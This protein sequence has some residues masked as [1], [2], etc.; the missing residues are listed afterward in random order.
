MRAHCIYPSSCQKA[1]HSHKEFLIEAHG[2]HHDEG[3]Q[4]RA[5]SYFA[6]NLKIKL[7]HIQQGSI[8]PSISQNT[9][10]K[11]Q[12]ELHI[13]RKKEKTLSSVLPLFRVPIILS[14]SPNTKPTI[15]K[16]V[17]KNFKRSIEKQYKLSVHETQVQA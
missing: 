3:Y 2:T 11:C 8:Y 4:V 5:P 16:F 9:H 15:V 17:P 10:I 14:Q 1:I 13:E 7:N 6:T 12:S